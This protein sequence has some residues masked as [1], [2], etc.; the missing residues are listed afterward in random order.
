MGSPTPFQL[1][2]EISPII[3]TGGIAQNMD[4]GMLPIVALTQGISFTTGLLEGVTNLDL[5]DF[6][7]HF[8]P[9]PGGTI[10]ENQ[11]GMYPFANQAVA[12]NA[13][14]VQPLRI[15]LR[16][17]C[18]AR[19]DLPYSA[20]LATFSALKASIDQHTN[21]G[22]TYTIATPSAIYVNCLL[23]TLKD[24]STGQTKQVQ[25]AWQWDFI[26]PLVSLQ[27]LQAAQNAWMSKVTNGLPAGDTWS[28]PQLQTGYQQGGSTPTLLGAAQPLSGV[29]P[30][31]PSVLSGF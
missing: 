19:P 26:Q 10:E 6:F 14:I 29:S 7:C 17:I 3:L 20:K 24:I 16:M 8:V 28:G 22:G 18:P 1:A 23:T 25:D 9:M 12:A 2:F 30:T 13:I 21:Q 4:G 27:Q 15:S 31:S 5:S 11:I